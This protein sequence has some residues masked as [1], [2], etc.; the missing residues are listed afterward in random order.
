MEK[1]KMKKRSTDRRTLQERVED[2]F[3]FIES[4]SEI[5]PKSRFKE[6][7]LN[8]R[9]A[10]KWLTLIEYIQK[11]P[12][13]RLIRTKNNTLVEKVEG[14]Y[15][16]LMRKMILDEEIPFDERLQMI[17]DYM[18][19]LYIRERLGDQKMRLS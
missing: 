10:E 17:T 1:A 8:P 15:Q 13:I 2:I 14:K 7:G 6:I 4:Q 12:R 3:N 9:T 19:A 11:Q 18:K 5:F 16:V